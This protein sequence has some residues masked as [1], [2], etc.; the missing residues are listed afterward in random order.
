MANLGALLHKEGLNF[1]EAESW[2]VRTLRS[3]PNDTST[4]LNYVELLNMRG[5]HEKAFLLVDRLL[6]ALNQSLSSA[7]GSASFLEQAPQSE[8]CNPAWSCMQLS[9]LPDGA[10]PVVLDA[11]RSLADTL[12]RANASEDAEEVYTHILSEFPCDLTSVERLARLLGARGECAQ[13]L[14]CYIQALDVSARLSSH[15]DDQFTATLWREHEASVRASFAEYLWNWCGDGAQ[16]VDELSRALASDCNSRRARAAFVEMMIDLPA[17]RDGEEMN[18]NKERLKAVN[19]VYQ[20]AVQGLKEMHTA[21]TVL[22]EEA[23]LRAEWVRKEK[24]LKD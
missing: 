24:S 2:Y 10:S 3:A 23:R 5:D 21:D 22:L 7:P 15:K 14:Q 11:Y 8:A 13:G 6:D 9:S 1:S 4:I 16:A 12:R 17:L 19:K 18:E 20:D